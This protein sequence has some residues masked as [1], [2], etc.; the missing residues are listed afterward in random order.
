MPDPASYELITLIKRLAGVLQQNIDLWLKPYDLART[1]YV[2][3]R[4]LPDE[5][6]LPTKELLAKLQVEP[7]TLS[8]LIDT[9]ETKGLVA[10][11]ERSEDKRRKDVWLTSAGRK[12]LEEIPP[13]GPVMEQAMLDGISPDQAEQLRVTGEKMLQNLEDELRNQER[14]KPC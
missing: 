4:N 1:Q 7:A 13:P 12:L 14:S 2:I 10:R 11:V 3:L 6:G 9:L 5:Q 8:G